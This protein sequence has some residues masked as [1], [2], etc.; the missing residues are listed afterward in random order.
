[1]SEVL[2]ILAIALAVAFVLLWAAYR[3]TKHRELWF[4][5]W[6]RIRIRSEMGVTWYECWKHLDLDT[7]WKQFTADYR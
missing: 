2:D 6:V 4:D 1:M 3:Y 7:L 5:T